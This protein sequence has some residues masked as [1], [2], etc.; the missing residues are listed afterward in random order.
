MTKKIY[1]KLAL[2]VAALM[3]LNIH[4]ETT[5]MNTTG[6]SGL[7]PEMQTFY[8]GYIVDFLKAN[9]I[10]RQFG[11]KKPVP[12][13]KGKTIT[14]HKRVKLPP[15]TVPL[16]EG[17]TPN[18]QELGMNE[19]VATLNE[20]GGY[21]TLTDMI[22]FVAI[23]P[24]VSEAVKYISEQAAE[25]IDLITSEVVYS[26]TNVLYGDGNA[27]DVDEVTSGMTMGLQ[28]IKNAVRI[29]KRN[30]VKPLEGGKY[31]LIVH[32][33]VGY[34]LQSDPAF[35][36]A[37]N[38]AAPQRLLNGEIGEISGARVVETTQAK[39]YAGAGDDDIDVYG[40]I[41]LGKEGYASCDLSGH[42]IEIIPKQLG[43]GGTADPL[44][45]RST[46]GWKIITTD[47]LLEE[48]AVL[49]IFTAV[50]QGE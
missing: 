2:F 46:V 37:I 49:Q 31:V 1:S 36:N 6:S 33:D 8:T 28:Y 35:I 34:D 26:T 38:Y 47:V 29:M 21:A 7:T 39:I 4:D 13:R 30:N 22:D 15:L 44:N 10:F 32:P 14:F 18:G 50:S 20:Y 19:I 25:S 45:Q 23:D 48:L 27:D 3:S 40:S 16:T 5:V 43:S 11:E 9:L 41:L 17:V 12:L 24:M 42:G